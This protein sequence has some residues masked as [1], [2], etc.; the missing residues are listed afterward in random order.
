MA[1]AE[2][3]KVNRTK[4]HARDKVREECQMIHSRREPAAFL[5]YNGIARKKPDGPCQKCTNDGQQE[6]VQKAI[7]NAVILQDTRLAICDVS[8]S[9]SDPKDSA[10]IAQRI[11]P[12]LNDERLY[13]KGDERDDSHAHEEKGKQERNRQAQTAKRDE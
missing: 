8:R 9:V 5:P 2:H 11:I 10:E 1:G 6:A 12:R 7:V 4:S 13:R 3:G